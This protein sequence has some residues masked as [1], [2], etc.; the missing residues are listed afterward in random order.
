MISLNKSIS[1]LQHFEELSAAALISYRGVIAAIRDY[2]FEFDPGEVE[3][4]RSHLSQVL[5]EVERTVSADVLQYTQRAACDQLRDYQ[6]KADQHFK[7]LRE[8]LATASEALIEILQSMSH[9]ES[10]PEEK[11][12]VGLARLR[13]IADQTAVVKAYPDLPKIVSTLEQGVTEIEKEHCLVVAQLRDEIRTLHRTIDRTN[14]GC[15]SRGVT[16]MSRGEIEDFVESEHQRGADCCL[17]L[18]L[19]ENLRRIRRQS[20][21]TIATEIL[22]QL[23]SKIASEARAATVGRWSDDVVVA[24]DSAGRESMEFLRQLPQ[25]LVGPYSISSGGVRTDFSLNL[26]TGIVSRGRYRDASKF[27]LACDQLATVLEKRAAK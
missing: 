3:I 15:A 17:F 21:S 11:L 10:H 13:L 9:R 25:R 18:V 5:Q 6:R 14:P 26:R 7:S 24:V 8:E 2:A 1:D 20:G 22:K 27:R 19:V 4:Y 12:K 23:S 16:L